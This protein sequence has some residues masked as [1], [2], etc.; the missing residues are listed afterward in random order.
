MI[1]FYG[2]DA[3]YIH[4]KFGRMQKAYNFTD[5]FREKHPNFVAEYEKH[6]NNDETCRFKT[7]LEIAQ[8]VDMYEV[9]VNFYFNFTDTPVKDITEVYEYLIREYS[10]I[11]YETDGSWRKEYTKGLDGEED[12]SKSYMVINPT[13]VAKTLLEFRQWDASYFEGG[14]VPDGW[15]Y[16][17]LDTLSRLEEKIIQ[18]CQRL[19]KGEADES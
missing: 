11:S 9:P 8:Y 12:K 18:E 17:L 13:Q 6:W 10:G 2:E 14:Q 7:P 15:S 1:D 4:L 19:V 3:D 5:G 16:D